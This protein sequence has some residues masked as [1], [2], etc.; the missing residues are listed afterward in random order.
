M[1]TS[2][3]LYISYLAILKGG[4]AF[5]PLPMDAPLERIRELIQDIM[6]PVVLGI[7]GKPDEWASQGIQTTWI[8]ATEIS[9]WKTLCNQDMSGEDS[10]SSFQPLTI[11]T[12]ALAYLLFTSGS[13]G[14]TKGVQISHLAATCSIASHSTA[15]ALPD[16][17][18]GCFRWFQFAAPTFDPSI[19]EIFV[20]LSN[21]G[22]LCAAPRELTL[23]DLEGTINEAQATIMMAT[24]SL[25]ALL[26]PSHLQTLRSLWC[27]GEKL[28]RTVID[29]FGMQSP[30]TPYTLANFYGPTE[31]AINCTVLVP[32]EYLVRGSIIGEA[33]PTCSLFV[34]D[35]KS[36]VCKVIPTG[37][38]GE[39]AIGG[40]QVSEG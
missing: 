36:Q 26:R 13:T 17:N 15:I 9:R 37:F 18:D 20:T 35:H 28:N 30:D 22:A 32:V 21:G 39:L 24:P 12:G 7:G 11:A 6:P 34:L 8:D 16:R 29:N 1:S 33:I 5:S 4:L 2:P 14:K 31:A 25:A 19:M 27:M 38:V 40:P 10:E 3:E 23:T